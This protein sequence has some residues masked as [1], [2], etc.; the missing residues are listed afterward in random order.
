MKRIA[1]TSLDYYNKSVI[2][3]IIDKYD[4]K[5]HIS[6]KAELIPTGISRPITVT[7]R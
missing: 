6:K 5:P 3:R 7:V 4:M 1:S 2:Q